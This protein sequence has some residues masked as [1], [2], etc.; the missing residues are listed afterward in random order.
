MIPNYQA[1][2]YNSYNE[3]PITEYFATMDSAKHWI[4]I[5]CFYTYNNIEN[6]EI[7]ENTDQYVGYI[8]EYFGKIAVAEIYKLSSGI[9]NTLPTE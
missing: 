9:D 5:Y 6:P 3:D 8:G 4:R 1:T 7:V 2:F